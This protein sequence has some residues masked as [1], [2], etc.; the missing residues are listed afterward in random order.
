[1]ID[2]PNSRFTEFEDEVAISST[3]SLN[4]SINCC[5]NSD[6][7]SLSTLSSLAS[8]TVWST[9]SDGIAGAVSDA[10]WETESS[11]RN[12]CC[13]ASL[14]LVSSPVNAFAHDSVVGGRRKSKLDRVGSTDG[15]GTSEIG[16]K[17][18][19]SLSLSLRLMLLLRVPKSKSM[20]LMSRLKDPPAAGPSPKLPMKESGWSPPVLS[21]E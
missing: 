10:S 8:C 18:S 15:R 12:S 21:G 3:I 14:N 6:L 13:G 19:L 16:R 9:T 17:S 7:D 1:M 11:R 20:A 5:S 2:S 4:R